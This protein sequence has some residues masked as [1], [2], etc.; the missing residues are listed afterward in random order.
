MAIGVQKWKGEF[1]LIFKKIFRLKTNIYNVIFVCFQT[2]RDKLSVLS[3]HDN[4]IVTLSARSPMSVL[5]GC[6]I[7]P[8]ENHE[9]FSSIPQPTSESPIFETT[10]GHDDENYSTETNYDKYLKRPLNEPKQPLENRTGKSLENFTNDEFD[11]SFNETEIFNN[12]AT[13]GDEHSHNGG[14]LVFEHDIRLQNELENTTEYKLEVEELFEAQN[15]T[16][17]LRPNIDNYK[18]RERRSESW[19]FRRQRDTYIVRCHNAGTFISSRERWWYIAISNCG[20]D[21]GLD[22]RYRFKMTNGKS[23]DFWNEH[24]SADE[25][26]NDSFII[27]NAHTNLIHSKVFT[28]FEFFIFSN[29]IDFI[30][31]I[32]CI[33]FT[34]GGIV[35][36]YG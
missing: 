35:F 19:P 28:L 2:C 34:D 23:G 8:K 14:G 6:T 16:E 30:D 4:Q 22:I 12:S 33:F 5:S 21:K 13:T 26:C 7:L 9:P 24:F 32:Y 36:L 15:Q 11:E 29:S 18:S 27:H 1:I 20:T 25:R 31:R 3:I 17:Y 10:E